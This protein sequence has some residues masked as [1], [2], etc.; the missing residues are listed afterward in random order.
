MFNHF[1][2]SSNGRPSTVNCILTLPL[3][4]K[5]IALLKK[6]TC[7]NACLLLAF[8]V[9]AQTTVTQITRNAFTGIKGRVVDAA[10]NT[11][12][13]ARISIADDTGHIYN[14]Y[15]NSL[16]GFFTEEDGSFAQPLAPG[17]YTVTVLHGIDYLSQKITL[18]VGRDSGCDVVVYLQPWVPLRKLGWVCGE[19]HDHLYTE[20]HPDTAMV[21]TLRKICLAQGIDFVCAA[22]GWAGYN[23]TTWGAGYAK[24]SDDRFTI[25]YGSEMPK[26][27]TGHTWWLGQLSTRNYFWSVM[28]TVHENQYFQADHGTSWNFKQLAFPF[29]PDVEV[30]ARFKM[31]DHSVAVMA[32]PTSWWM[33]QRGSIEKHV[34]NVAANLPFGLLSG[35]I[36]DGIVVMGYNHDH[37]YYQNLWF[38]ILNEGYRMAAMSELDGGFEKDDP[39]YY[40][41]MRTYSKIEGAFTVEKL[42]QAVRAG[43]TFVSSGPIIT[44]DVDGRYGIGDIVP[45]NGKQ[46]TLHIHAYA[47]GDESDHLSYIV[48]YRN[49][50]IFKQWDVRDKKLRRFETSIDITEKEKAWYIIKIYGRKAWKS[51]AYLDVMQVCDKADTARYPDFGK[52]KNEV[53]ITSP[54][55]FWPAEAKEPGVLQ[56]AI[57]LTVVSPQ[58]QQPLSNVTVEILVAEK[59]IKTMVL[60]G[61]RS[62]FGMPVNGVLKISANGYAPIYRT[63]YLDY[64]PHLALIE[65]LATGKW[66]D[67]YSTGKF[68]PGEVPWEAFQFEKAKQVLSQVDWQIEMAPNE[69]DGLWRGFGGIFKSR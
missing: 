44:A 43:K 19:G 3:H 4:S 23:D 42:A 21:A 56:S 31:A 50:L 1:P 27:R 53:A 47:A 46:H 20:K 61:G 2:F 32:H 66:R 64:P 68:Y 57:T 60:P 6:I 29:I 8:F 7:V 10:A 15:Y 17:H 65:E 35:K 5:C 13:S 48:V 40:G 41:S 12:L 36:W 30:V 59:K 28:D 54:F 33:Q 22:Q 51:P 58:T 34:T 62:T 45:V 63:L 11:P 16:P 52:V 67:K 14:T 26:Y 25:S 37:Y 55:Y 49:G 38:N 18:T 69:R 9:Y 24:F 39:K